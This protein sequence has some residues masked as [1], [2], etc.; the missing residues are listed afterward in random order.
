[1]LREPRLE[2]NNP[3]SSGKLILP[4]LFLHL[5][6]PHLDIKPAPNWK[7]CLFIGQTL[8][9][10]LSL[11]PK[12]SGKTCVLFCGLPIVGTAEYDVRDC[13]VHR[14]SMWVAAGRS[15]QNPTGM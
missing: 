3:R 11:S 13:L 15:G 1:M 6:Y 9:M 12:P 5:S 4:S 14:T 2:S 8:A 7:H 10:S